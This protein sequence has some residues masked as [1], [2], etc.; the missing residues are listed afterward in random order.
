MRFL[1]KI[2]FDFLGRPV[3]EFLVVA[4]DNGNPTLQ[5]STVLQVKIIGSSVTVPVFPSNHYKLIVA[6]DATTGK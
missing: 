2:Y 4:E 1:T 3:Y 6:E 5:S